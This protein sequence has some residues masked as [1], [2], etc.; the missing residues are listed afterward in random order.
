MEPRA[1]CP[2]AD[3]PVPAMRIIGD[4]PLFLPYRPPTDVPASGNRLV[5]SPAL[6]AICGATVCR[7]LTLFG[8]GFRGIF[9]ALAIRAMWPLLLSM[10]ARSSRS[11]KK[12][13][14]PARPPY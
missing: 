10:G 1:E 6:L 5:S 3:I 2:V 7:M 14:K 9:W 12:A 4:R 13:A 11:R 8:R